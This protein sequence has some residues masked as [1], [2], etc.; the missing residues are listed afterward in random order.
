[1]NVVNKKVPSKFKNEVK[2]TKKLKIKWTE[3]FEKF[4][5]KMFMIG[6]AYESLN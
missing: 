2:M 1:M 4:P 5:P 6:E 3:L